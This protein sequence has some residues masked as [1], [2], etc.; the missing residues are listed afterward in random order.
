MN[1]P[2]NLPLRISSLSKSD[3]D[4]PMWSVMIMVSQHVPFLNECLESVLA[5]GIPAHEMQIEVI[6]DQSIDAQVENIVAEVGRGRIKYFAPER[7]EEDGSFFI[8]KE[9]SI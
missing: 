7:N 9:K 6:G 5:Q 1:H 8:S 4:Q 3:S 2:F